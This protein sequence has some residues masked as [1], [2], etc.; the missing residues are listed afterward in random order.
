[1]EVIAARTKNDTGETMLVAE[2]PYCHETIAYNSNYNTNECGHFRGPI[3][4][5]NA[6]EFVEE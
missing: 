4:G 1:M 6:L 3:I 5:K 2:C